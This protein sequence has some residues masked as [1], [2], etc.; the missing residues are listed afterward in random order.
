MKPPGDANATQAGGRRWQSQFSLLRA[1]RFGP[2]F[3]TQSCGTFND[4]IFKSTLTVLFTFHAVKWS[5]L[6]TEVLI[7][8][9][10]ALFILPFFL[11]SATAG[12]LADKY[13]KAR[14]ARLTK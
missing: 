5:N 13:D 1:R 8:L 12:N 3:V 4:N 7:N 11:F 6:Q 2:L 14:L 10:Q 9:A